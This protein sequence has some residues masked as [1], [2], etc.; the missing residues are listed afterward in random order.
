MKV[1]DE[2]T[3]GAASLKEDVENMVIQQEEDE[4]R[5][6]FEIREQKNITIIL[7]RESISFYGAESFIQ[8][9]IFEHLMCK[10]P[11]HQFGLFL[12]N[13]YKTSL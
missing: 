4:Q 1:A 12:L 11:N 5:S 9:H 13:S 7:R 10:R 2:Q 8:C 6:C 3:R